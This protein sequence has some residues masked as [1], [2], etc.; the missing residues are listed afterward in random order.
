MKSDSLTWIDDGLAVLESGAWT[1][2]KYLT[3]FNCLEI[4]S[5]GMKKKWGKRIY[6]DL[7]AGPG[8]ARIEGS[9]RLL[10]GSPL[11]ALSVK[12][13]FD[14]Y[15]FCEMMP[16]SL[17]ALEKRVSKLDPSAQVAYVPGDCNVSIDDIIRQIPQYS[18]SSTVLTFCFV[19]P[20]D[21][22]VQFKTLRKLAENRAT[23]FMVL[24]ALFMDANRN[25]KHYTNPQ[26]TKVDLFLDSSNWRTVWEGQRSKDGSFPRFL[27]QE[28]EKKMLDIGYLRSY[29]NTKEFRSTEKNLPLYHLAFFSRSQRGY[30]FWKKG[31]SYSTPQISMDI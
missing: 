21:L 19:D 20:F 22:S 28:F 27:A 29:Q 13:R 5:T 26:N 8:C 7:Y 17:D 31:T 15:I 18:K 12:S 9:G 30:D 3:L 24:L 10:R 14:K 11:L 6:L 1:E 16:D 2:Q 23:D 25:E 4:F